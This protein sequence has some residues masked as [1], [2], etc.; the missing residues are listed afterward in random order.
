MRTPWKTWCLFTG[1]LLVVLTAM[2]WI[3][4]VTLRLERAESEAQV[5]AALE[6]NVRLA[7]WRMESSLAPLLPQESAR[8]Y[9]VYSAFYPSGRAYSCMF[10][11]PQAGESLVP[12]PILTRVPEQVLLHFQIS[13]DGEFTSPQI[14]GQQHTKAFMGC[15]L[16]LDGQ[17]VAFPC[18]QVEPSSD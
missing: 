7:L 14:A 1:A 10:D 4:V 5:Q 11:E 16:T 12:S 6:E 2:G 15:G 17:A 9:F 13:P 8:P 3:S 18:R